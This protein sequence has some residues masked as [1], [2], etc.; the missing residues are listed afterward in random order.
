MTW[1]WVTLQAKLETALIFWD[2]DLILL[3]PFL[4]LNISLF[5]LMLAP[6][7]SSFSLSTSRWLAIALRATG[8]LV[9]SH[10]TRVC[11]S[12][13]PA[14]VFRFFLIGSFWTNHDGKGECNSDW[15]SQIP[16]LDLE[17]MSVLLR[18]QAREIGVQT[19]RGWW[20]WVAIPKSPLQP[21]FYT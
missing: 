17:G 4:K 16:S 18:P 5:S 8:F 14:K 13:F 10:R 11:V 1:G 3:C 20:W 9:T 15:S 2:Q 6:F 21:L 19:V 7:L 12:A